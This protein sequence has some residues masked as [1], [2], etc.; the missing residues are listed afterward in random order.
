LT[1]RPVL[2]RLL[3]G[4]LQLPWICFGDVIALIRL[5]VT[6]L[7]IFLTSLLRGILVVLSLVWNALSLTVPLPALSRLSLTL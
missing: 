3:L 7:L 1:C 2:W 6:G 4:V 5:G